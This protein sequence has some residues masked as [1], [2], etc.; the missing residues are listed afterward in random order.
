MSENEG[1]QYEYR[2][3]GAGGGNWRVT[4]WTDLE[5]ALEDYEKASDSWDMV[6]FER[7]HPGDDSTIERK[8]TPDSDEWNE[9]TEDMLHVKTEV[10]A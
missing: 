5:T 3:M 10:T 2:S 1:N 9:V 8:P 6:G 4:E 7:R